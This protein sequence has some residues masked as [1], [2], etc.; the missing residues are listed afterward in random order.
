[1]IPVQDISKTV[2]EITRTGI[3]EKVVI[4]GTDS[5]NFERRTDL[6]T[7]VVV[8]NKGKGGRAFY[9]KTSNQ[10]FNSL[11]QKLTTEAWLSVQTAF[12]I[13]PLLPEGCDLIVHLD[14]NPD[15]KKGKSAMHIK[16]VVG[17]VA[18]QGFAVVTKPD[19]FVA[20][21]I[22]EHIVKRKNETGLSR[23]QRKR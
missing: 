20:S 4:I 12:E 2:Y 17:M 11:R 18:G 21:H 15:L 23:R 22:A 1:M 7:A 8:L 16:E 5:Q 19:G 3:Y 6:V 9:T 13:E 10:K 14:V